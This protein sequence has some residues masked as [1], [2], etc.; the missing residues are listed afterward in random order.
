MTIRSCCTVSSS[1]LSAFFT[2]LGKGFHARLDQL[3][4]S[5]EYGEI[6]GMIMISD[7]RAAIEAPVLA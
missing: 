5:F 1:P 4:S 2:P 6:S 3:A 7:G